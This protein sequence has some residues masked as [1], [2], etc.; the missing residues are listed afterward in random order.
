MGV[1]VLA[2][3]AQALTSTSGFVDTVKIEMKGAAKSA[4]VKLVF[5]PSAPLNLCSTVI[6]G[7]KTEGEISEGGSSSNTGEGVSAI[8][9]ML[10]EAK[11]AGRKVQI[12]SENGTSTTKGCQVIAVTLL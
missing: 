9:S 3:N 1:S 6:N 12:W 8:V 7:V 10:L 2:M 4:S 5:K 11:L